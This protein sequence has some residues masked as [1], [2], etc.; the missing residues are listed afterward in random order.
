[1]RSLYRHGHQFKG[2]G[3]AVPA[4]FNNELLNGYDAFDDSSRS[5]ARGDG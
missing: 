4:V 1:M 5:I 2:F 3:D